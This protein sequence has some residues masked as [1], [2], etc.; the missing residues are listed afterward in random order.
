MEAIMRCA[1]CETRSIEL[2][3]T[4]T[5]G[6]TVTLI[7]CGC[8]R[9]WFKGGQAVSLGEVMTAVPRR[10]PRAPYRGALQAA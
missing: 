6:Q 3:M 5:D 1:H 8:T 4:V 7:S 2:D 9:Q 10:R